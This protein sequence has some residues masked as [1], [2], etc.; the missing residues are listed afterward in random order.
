[1]KFRAFDKTTNKM[2]YPP[3]SHI[4]LNINGTCVN[5]QNGE[6]LEPMFLAKQNGV[7]VYVGDIVSVG[8][9]ALIGEVVFNG[10]GFQVHLGDV[11]TYPL[12]DPDL[13]PIGVLG[14]I[15][16]HKIEDFQ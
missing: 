7:D 12:E 15:K 14:N 1:M 13:L 6:E 4:Y 10:D 2:Y 8:D 5:F 16:Q 3:N 9:E 11:G